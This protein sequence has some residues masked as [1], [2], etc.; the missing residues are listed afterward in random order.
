MRP[1]QLCRRVS[2]GALVLTMANATMMA[3]DPAGATGGIVTCTSLSGNQQSPAEL[4]NCSDLSGTGGNGSIQPNGPFTGSHLATIY[5]SGATT[6]QPVTTVIHISTH[7]VTRQEDAVWGVHRTAG[8]GT[9][10]VRHERGRLGRREG[11]GRS[12][13]GVER[14]FLARTEQRLLSL[15]LSEHVIPGAARDGRHPTAHRP[16]ER[17]APPSQE[18]AGDSP[19]TD[20][21]PVR[22]VPCGP[23]AQ[24]VGAG[25][26]IV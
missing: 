4:F 10:P 7:V 15:I 11:V 17:T 5:W 12:L 22:F 14:K 26:S 1:L 6:N 9:G 21:R 24:I 16:F 19:G 23:D 13:R 2:L 25:G 8:V 20:E 18:V 3:C